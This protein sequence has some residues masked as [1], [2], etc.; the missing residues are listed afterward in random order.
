MTSSGYERPDGPGPLDEQFLNGELDQCDWDAPLTRLLLLLELADRPE[1]L[2][3][4]ARSAQR[5]PSGVA[6][7]RR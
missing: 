4:L 7:Q 5:A 2:Q 6:G 3:D 1:W